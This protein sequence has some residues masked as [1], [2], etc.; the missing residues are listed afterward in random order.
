[1]KSRRLKGE[2]D[3]ANR[4]MWQ[5]IGDR[6]WEGIQQRLANGEWNPNRPLV[7]ALQ[8][9]G[10]LLLSVAV[11][12]GQVAVARQLIELGADV[13]AHMPGEIQPLMEACDASN[14][15]MV[16]LLL[17]AGANVNTKCSVSDEGDAGE[18]PLMAAVTH[19]DIVEMLLR[20]GAR[21]DATTRRGRSVLSRLLETELVDLDMVRFLLD[22]GCPVDGRDLHHPILQRSLNVVKLLL[23]RKPDVNKPFDW[24]T[25][26]GSPRK[27]DTPIFVAVDRNADEM[28][29]GTESEVRKRAERLAIIDLL[30]EAGAEVNG[31]RGGKMSTWTPLRMAIAQD[32][33]EIV[34]R[35][36]DAGAAT[37][38]EGETSQK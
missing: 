29:E 25:Y 33:A 4:V 1:M 3:D 5:L 36:I 15:E 2:A 14:R 11:E 37:T 9:G 19:R 24:P 6:N 23:A 22:A 8:S 28:L 12:H 30:I 7:L 32:D 10:L 20:N 38:N 31:Q 21:I 34:K 26:L 16:E 17:Q 35:L 27:G 18:T 13:N